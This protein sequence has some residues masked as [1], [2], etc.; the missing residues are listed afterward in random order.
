LSVKVGVIGVGYLGQHHA[1]IYSGMAGVELVGI[2][3]ESVERASEIGEAFSCTVYGE[4]EGLIRECDAL[5]IAA[6]TPLHYDIAMKCLEYGKDI[7][8]EKPITV[9]VEEADELIDVAGKKGLILQVGHLERFN[10]AVMEIEKYMNKPQFFESERSSPFIE[11]AAGVDVTL[12]LMIHDIDII[13]FLSGSQPKNVSA[14]GTAVLSEKL[15]VAKAWIN[16]ENGVSALISAGRL[17]QDKTRKLKIFQEDSYIVLDYQQAMIKRHYKTD[18]NKIM[19]DTIKPEDREPLMEE[20]HDFI[21][22]INDRSKPVVSGTEAR[23]ALK[24]ALNITDQLK[25]KKPL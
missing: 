7:L 20:L 9:T 14:V 15:D 18:T 23:N 4:M 8:V 19:H 17:S 11:R 3:D 21:R 13:L 12:D 16:F 5:S 10:P 24:I 25:G 2:M 6:P 1:R 22:C